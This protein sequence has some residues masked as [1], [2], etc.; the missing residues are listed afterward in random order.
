MLF[1]NSHELADVL[2]YNGLS[3]FYFLGLPQLTDDSLSS[4]ANVGHTAFIGDYA[5]M[6]V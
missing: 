3:F 6:I 1:I 4:T 5:L 2:N